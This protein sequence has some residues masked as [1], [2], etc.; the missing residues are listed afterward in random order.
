MTK[1]LL[2][3]ML[4]TMIAAAGCSSHDMSSFATTDSAISGPNAFNGALGACALIMDLTAPDGKPNKKEADA[5][6]AKRDAEIAKMREESDRKYAE[7]QAKQQA[8]D[9]Q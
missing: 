6:Y 3:L 5:Y 1:T 4:A 7:E 8:E 2:I 9:E